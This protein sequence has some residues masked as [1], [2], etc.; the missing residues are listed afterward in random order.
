MVARRCL[1]PGKSITHPAQGTPEGSGMW[2][3][4]LHPILSC[5]V[6]KSCPRSFR[7]TTGV[8]LFC[9]AIMPSTY[10]SLKAHIVFS[11]KNRE[12]WFNDED[13]LHAMHAILGGALKHERCHPI[14]IGGIADHVHLLFGFKP[15]HA[16]SDV[17]REIKKI[18]SAWYHE[19]TGRAAFAWQGGYGAFTVSPTGVEGVRAYIQNQ[20][21]HHRKMT[22]R[23]ELIGMLK[24]AGIEPD[25][26]YFD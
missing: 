11:T 13:T 26:R 8:K 15:T 12:P 19:K 24:K 10:S 9:I 1:H 17:V 7:L 4:C 6:Y 18:S 25:M 3:G 20:K 23:E 22:Y 16:L 21:E 2:G 14:E 5:L